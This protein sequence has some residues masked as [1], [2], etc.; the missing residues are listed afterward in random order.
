METEQEV[1]FDRYGRMN[2]HPAYHGKQGTP[3]STQDQKFLVD[4]YETFGPEKISLAL[5]RTIHTVMTRAYELRKKGV[6]PKPKK[7]VVHRRLISSSHREK[8]V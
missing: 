8:H 6:M 2:Y 3:W 4:N 7:K 1:T 5:E